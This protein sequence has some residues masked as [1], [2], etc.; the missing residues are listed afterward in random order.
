M[1]TTLYTI[2]QSPY[3]YEIP[4]D[5]LNQI[6][7]THITKYE[8]HE[9]I[10]LLKNEQPYFLATFQK[11]LHSALVKAATTI[12]QNDRKYNPAILQL[13]LSEVVSTITDIPAYIAEYQKSLTVIAPTITDLPKRLLLRKYIKNAAPT[14]W[15]SIRQA[16]SPCYYQIIA[17]YDY[18]IEPVSI[19]VQ[20]LNQTLQ[21]ATTL[22]RHLVQQI[23]ESVQP[24]L[25]QQYYQDPIMLSFITN[26][27]SMTH[28]Q[29]AAFHQLHAPYY[30]PDEIYVVQSV[31][32]ANNLYTSVLLVEYLPTIY[33]ALK[34]NLHKI[35]EQ[36]YLGTFPLIQEN[37]IPVAVLPTAQS[38]FYQNYLKKNPLP[39]LLTK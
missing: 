38:A 1:N 25:V 37:T 32:R 31:I 33:K 19:A 12:Y 35:T 6:V 13:K 34:D 29:I 7:A 10:A 16:Y 4:T 3:I 9:T 20:K 36:E 15:A 17:D 39:P 2:K 26:Y 24:L 22:R 14:D 18:Y 5:T 21:Q 23:L 28:R 27:H 8:K 11:R 30:R